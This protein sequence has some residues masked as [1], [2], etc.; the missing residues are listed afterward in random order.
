MR[1]LTQ[2]GIGSV[3]GLAKLVEY[4]PLSQ[5]PGASVEAKPSLLDCMAVY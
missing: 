4:L 1:Q 5:F 2:E 3:L